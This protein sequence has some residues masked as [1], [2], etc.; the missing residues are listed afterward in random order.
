MDDGSARRQVWTTLFLML[1]G[2]ICMTIYCYFKAG[3][4]SAS[5]FTN[6]PVRARARAPPPCRPPRG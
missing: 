5:S 3:M 6:I 2:M 1:V 4:L